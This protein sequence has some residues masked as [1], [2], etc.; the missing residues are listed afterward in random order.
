MRG[1]ALIALALIARY[2]R[3]RAQERAEERNQVHGFCT[4]CSKFTNGP[5]D[6]GTCNIISKLELAGRIG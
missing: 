4:A 1:A 2:D 5:C 6:A 3:R